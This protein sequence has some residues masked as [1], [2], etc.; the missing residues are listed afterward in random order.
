MIIDHTPTPLAIQELQW[1]YT[2]LQTWNDQSFPTTTPQHE[3]FIDASDQGWVIAWKQTLGTALGR[4]KSAR[5]ISIVK[6]FYWSGRQSNFVHYWVVNQNI[7]RQYDSDLVH[8]QVWRHSVGATDGSISPNIAILPEDENSDSSDICSF[9]V[10]PGRCSV[11]T[12]DS[13]V[14]M[15]DSTSILQKTGEVMWSPSNR[16]V[17][18]SPEPPTSLYVMW[19]IAIGLSSLSGSA[20]TSSLWCSYYPTPRKAE[21]RLVPLA[22]L[23]LSWREP[24]SMT[25]YRMATGPVKRYSTLFIVCLQRR[26]LTSPHWR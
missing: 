2:K 17:C 19:G 13:A 1:W 16:H 8:Q 4:H 20:S 14:R 5:N 12:D 26:T 24:P 10:Q 7:L 11:Q 23:V 6:N 21:W 22:L 15:E 3:V 9:T 18:I 25:W